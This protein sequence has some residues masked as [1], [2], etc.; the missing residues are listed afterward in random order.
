MKK[1]GMRATALR[2]V[3]AGGLAAAV[4]LPGAA[5]AQEGG[6]EYGSGDCNPS[7]TAP[8]PPVKQQETG[9]VQ[10]APQ[11]GDTLPFTGGDAVGLA[12]I[13]AGAVLGGAAL[14]R[15]SRKKHVEA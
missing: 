15:G 11:E 2:L 5:M 12:L 8:E 4:M 3:A 6:C 14:A 10:G 7:T 1:V 9:G 13:G